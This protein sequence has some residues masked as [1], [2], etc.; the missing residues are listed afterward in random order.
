MGFKSTEELFQ[1]TRELIALLDS[2]GSH[3]AAQTLKDGFG[4]LNGLG[5]GWAYFLDA[6]K[7]VRENPPQQLDAPE[8]QRLDRIYDAAYFAV[9]RRK[10]RWW[11]FW[12]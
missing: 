10:S 9:Y 12:L 7:K 6:V 3:T 11:R 8:R 4:G 2:K 1:A 5:D